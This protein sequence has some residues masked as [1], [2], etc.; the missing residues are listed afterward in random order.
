MTKPKLYVLVGVPGAGKSTWV[1]NQRW[2]MN[3]TMFVS[4]DDHVEAYAK[5]V[6]KTYNEVFK[7]YMPTAVDLMTQ[8]VIRAREAGKDIVWDQTSTTV[9]S[10]KRKFNMLPDYYAIAVIFPTPEKAEL[11]KRLAGRP[12]KHIPRHVIRSMIK[13]WETPTENEGFAEIWQT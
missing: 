10:R 4:T 5:S 13:G 2:D 7:D 6:G 11:E 3:N 12:G 9:N 8:D 1:A